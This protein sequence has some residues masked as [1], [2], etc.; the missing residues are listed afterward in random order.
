[1]RCVYYAQS[2]NLHIVNCFY[3]S[4]TNTEIPS[5]ENANNLSNVP[6]LLK[7]TSTH[8]DSAIIPT[9]KAATYRTISIYENSRASLC[10]FGDRGYGHNRDHGL[11]PDYGRGHDRVDGP[12]IS[13]ANGVAPDFHQWLRG[14]GCDSDHA[15]AHEL[16]LMLLHHALP[17]PENDQLLLALNT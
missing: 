11:G 3:A 9:R 6:G 4:T 17:R 2:Y 1:M 13:I 8:A 15:E 10:G 14:P 16:L 12:A 5:Y 7:R